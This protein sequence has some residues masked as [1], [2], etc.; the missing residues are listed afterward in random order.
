MYQTTQGNPLFVD[1]VVRQIRTHGLGAGAPVP[2]G[3]REIIRQRLALVSDEGRRALE[4]GAILGVEFSAVDVG[5][6]VPGAAGV[7]DHAA[8]AGLVTTH[9][10]YREALYHDLPRPRRQELHREAARAVAATSGPLAETAHHLLESGPDVAAEAIDHAI[11]GA[12]HA[13]GVFAFEDATA[14]LERA[15]AAI[16]HGPMETPLRCRVLIALGEAQIRSGD[17]AGRA[18]CVEAAE[19]ARRIDDATLLALAGLAYGAVFTMGGV[20]P[21]LVGLLEDA[22]ARLP[23]EDS[24]LRARVMARLGA[25]RQPSAPQLRARDIELALAAVAMARRVADRRELLGVLH[26]ASGALYGAA[27]PAIRL[28]ISREQERLA[29]ELGD[30]TRLLHARVRLAMDHLELA[31]FAAYEQLA[32]SYEQLARRVGRAA[33]PWRAAL[34]RSMVALSADRFA[35]SERWQ[36]E[37]RSLET[38]HSAARRAASYHRLCFL[39]ATERHAEMRARIPELRGLWME[40][41]YGVVLAEPRV[42][43]TLARIGADD[44][45]RAILATITD[46]AFEELINTPPL[47]EAVWATGDAHHAARLIPMFAANSD[48]WFIYWLDVEIVEAPMT[49]LLAYLTAITGDW[50]GAERL[51]AQALAAVEGTGRR[52]MAARMRF[53]LGDLMIRMKR[54]P[55]RARSLLADARAG[56]E[57]VGLPLVALIDRRHPELAGPRTGTPVPFA[58][59]LEGEYFAIATTG[60]TLRFKASRGMHYLAR[61]VERPGVE[62]HV[63]ELAGSAEHA[64]RGDGGEQ[65][66]AAAMRAY[67]ARLETLRDTAEDAEAR[68]DADGAA[69]ARDEMEAIAGELT[70]GTGLGGQARRTVSAVDRARSAVQ[71]RI[72]DAIDRISE[73]DADLGSRLRRGVTTGNFCS[74]R[75][76]D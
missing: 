23:D 7:L 55:A 58:M 76:G 1:E 64:D 47:A 18:L 65:L 41:P 46:A 12:A 30:T 27:H 10:L 50:D 36:D 63:L 68:G 16:P 4:A 52:S 15:R 43:S 69:R 17:V 57:A 70:R 72:K 38:E 26:S 31:D 29:E 19:I 67:R 37:A 34:M 54:D 45:A 48:R 21:V 14:L 35:E 32:T 53:E 73:Q 20:D 66:D 33:A 28:P 74:F 24:A 42:A 71:R 2:L 25:A 60:G 13:L 59:L 62:I 8:R 75:I 39:R 6:M 49:R 51:F 44:E 3:V 22:L 40:M 56:A 5:R 11:R 9:A 61:L